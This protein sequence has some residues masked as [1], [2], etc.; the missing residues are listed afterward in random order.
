MSPS[1]LPT[2]PPANP[3]SPAIAAFEK[4]L[5][6][7]RDSALL[8]FGLGKEYLKAGQSARA[9]LMF[10]SAVGRDPDYSAA[11]KA[12]AKALADAGRHDEARPAFEQGIAVAERRGDVQAAKEMRV[13]LKRLGRAG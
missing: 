3:A 11:W 1:L 10:E 4:M 12:L 13:F 7:P 6:G 8:R 5:D 2:D 9:I